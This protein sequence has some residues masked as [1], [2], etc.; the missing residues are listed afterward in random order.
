MVL[1]A[2]PHAALIPAA[3]GMACSG[4]M[5]A[6]VAVMTPRIVSDFAAPGFYSWVNGTY[7]VFSLVFLVVGAPLADRWGARRSYA[8]GLAIYVVG[9]VFAGL[10]SS[11]LVFLLGR[12]LQGMGAGV[13]VPA[14]L[15]VV[16]GM[17]EGERG[18]V[19][20]VLGL[21]QVVA[22]VAGPLLGSY[23]AAGP[24]WR[25]GLLAVVPVAVCGVALALVLIPRTPRSTP[26]A[27]GS[28]RWRLSAVVPRVSAGV[29]TRFFVLSAIAGGLIAVA[30][31]YLPWELDRL[32]GID[33][34]GMGL[35]LVPCFL[36]AAAGSLTGGMFSQSRW[37]LIVSFAVA[38]S[39]VGVLGANSVVALSLGVALICGG[40]AG[41]LPMI[42]SATQAVAPP[43]QVATTSSW[44]QL[45]RHAGAAVL[46]PAFGVCTR[47]SLG[48]ASLCMV[49]LALLLTA[50]GL[51]VARSSS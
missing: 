15:L 16:G 35:W 27:H 10:A 41:S 46:V 31:T 26:A 37:G 29:L 48:T 40:C 30:V 8:C 4:L 6:M 33:S 28:H 9:T 3:V 12:L 14:A 36:A 50:G 24:G 34:A 42:L 43:D 39:G 17:P 32:H 2:C 23:F 49:I 38:A 51:V 19:F 11:M 5:H 21:V 20:G 44:V 18:R 13:V 47:F 22:Q 1:R 25:F 7:F 45:G